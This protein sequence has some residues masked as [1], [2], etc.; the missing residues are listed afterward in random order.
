[1]Y[2]KIPNGFSIR[3]EFLN[4]SHCFYKIVIVIYNYQSLSLPTCF[5]LF[6]YH[7]F[8]RDTCVRKLGTVFYRVLTILLNNTRYE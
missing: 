5:N 3:I 1:M 2:S 6:K 7:Y 8:Y 4:P